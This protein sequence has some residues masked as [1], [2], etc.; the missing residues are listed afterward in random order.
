[1]RGRIVFNTLLI[2]LIMGILTFIGGQYLATNTD[3]NIFEAAF[4]KRFFAR[5]AEEPKRAID[6]SLSLL[7]KNVE[8]AKALMPDYQI[9][10]I[11]E[12]DCENGIEFR[13]HGRIHRFSL[14]MTYRCRIDQNGN[15]RNFQALN[16]RNLNPE[17][18]EAYRNEG[19]LS[20]Y[21]SSVGE[22]L[23]LDPTNA[24]Q[25][26]PVAE[27]EKLVSSFIYPDEEADAETNSCAKNIVF[28][29]YK[30]FDF[31]IGSQQNRRY[32]ALDSYMNFSILGNS[33]W[34]YSICD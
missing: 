34:M 31:V 11:R 12:G 10:T 8:E 19:I 32:V 22:F 4:Y 16:N 25:N 17:E 21:L 18:I 33:P 15:P 20:S 14:D 29:I 3:Y 2:S 7:G 9:I 28:G 5:E 30:D 23:D 13:H 6:W 24:D 1:M 26:I 27:F